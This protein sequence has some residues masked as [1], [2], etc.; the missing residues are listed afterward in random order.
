[1]KGVP[2]SRL[3][4][5][6][7]VLCSCQDELSTYVEGVVSQSVTTRCRKYRLILEEKQVF[8]KKKR[9]V[10]DVLTFISSLLRVK[11]SAFRNA[12]RCIGADPVGLLTLRSIGS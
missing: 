4:A 5:I 8:L 1:M 7:I 12:F 10:G 11:D 9:E 2:F 6:S 3:H